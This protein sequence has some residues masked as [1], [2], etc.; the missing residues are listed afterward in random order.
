MLFFKVARF[1][2]FFVLLPL[3]GVGTLILFQ[4]SPTHR[5]TNPSSF[6][7]QGS[8]R[9]NCL[10]K[11]KDIILLSKLLRDSSEGSVRFMQMQPEDLHKIPPFNR[12]PL[13]RFKPNFYSL[14]DTVIMR[15]EICNQDILDFE[16]DLAAH[17]T[18]ELTSRGKIY[19]TLHIWQIIL[20]KLL[21]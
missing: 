17:P 6:C 5:Y 2:L 14:R 19:Y 18:S 20:S 16:A 3:G 11:F 9:S 10:Q 12:W 4:L 7:E 1:F 15:E 8:R 13:Y 21:F